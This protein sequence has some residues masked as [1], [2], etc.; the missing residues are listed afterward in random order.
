MGYSLKNVAL[1]LILGSFYL[2][3][4]ESIDKGITEE[5]SPVIDA[6]VSYFTK[7]RTL[8]NTKEIDKQ[9]TA[10][11]NINTDKLDTGREIIVAVFDTGLDMKN[12]ANDLIVYKE[13]GKPVYKN[14]VSGDKAPLRD[15]HGH[16]TN[17]S[18]IITAVNPR[19]KVLPI[20][21]YERMGKGKNPQDFS[22]AIEWT[23]D[24]YPEVKVY[25]MSVAG[26]MLRDSEIKALQKARALG[27]TVVA[28]A[29]NEGINIDEYKGFPANLS[30]KTGHIVVG[31]IFDDGQMN[32]N[33]N[34]S[35]TRVDFVA[36]GA[37]YPFL[38]NKDVRYLSG[39][40]Q[41]TAVISGVVSH[42]ITRRPRL[43]VDN[44]KELLARN[45]YPVK[46]K[47]SKNGRIAYTSL[48]AELTGDK[49]TDRNVASR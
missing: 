46:D 15:D 9:I 19:V 17:I 47:T 4:S 3:S 33:S 24:N 22:K 21:V 27:V 8:F 41:A 31:N 1:L 11:L 35:D 48:F 23:L 45:S 6:L 25:N 2:T 39:T 36:E 12:P 14:F 26:G 40:S 43:N 5:E 34:Y 42:I 49:G 10:R 32:G 37:N 30:N 29:G 44:I 20:I 16:G 28:S 18:K 13:N 38:W 7:E